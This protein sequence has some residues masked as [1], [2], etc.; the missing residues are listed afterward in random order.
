MLQVFHQG[1]RI[2]A[3]LDGADALLRRGHENAAERAFAHGKADDLARASPGI[4]AGLEP[5]LRR[6][7]LVEAARGAV[8][9]I[10][11]RLGD[12]RP[13]FQSGRRPALAQHLK[14]APGV[15][16]TIRLKAR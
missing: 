5:E 2:A 4:C 7:R 16:P 10:V 9:R 6:Q 15:T 3:K 12:A 1:L 11:D 8:T 14:Y 13:G